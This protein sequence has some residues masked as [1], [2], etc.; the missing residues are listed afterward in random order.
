MGLGK[1][2][3]TI[4][5]LA[6]LYESKGDL[7]DTVSDFTT[8]N[9]GDVLDL[10][11]YHASSIAAAGA[12]IPFG[13]NTFAYTHGYIRFEQNGADTNV[14]YDANGFYAT[15]PGQILATLTGVNA[16][17]ILPGVNSTPALSD[18]LFLIEQAPLDAGLSEDAAAT[19]SYRIV[20]GKA[21]TAD[22]AVTISGG[23]QISINNAGTTSSITFTADN[24]WQAQTITV[25]AVDDLV[26]EGDS[27]SAKSFA[28]RQ[29]LGKQRHVQLSLERRP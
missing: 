27:T 2:L 1:T 26:I 9:G 29:G 28:S 4:S 11:S 14:V 3:Q 18:K 8:G 20:L 16:S 15:D 6:W 21:P 19:L 17:S 13:A 5:L 12:A 22:V 25:K 7:V 10:A 23:D 24:W